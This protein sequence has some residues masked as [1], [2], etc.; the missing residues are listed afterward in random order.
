MDTKLH[1]DTESKVN[2][3]QNKE[4]QND[5]LSQNSPEHMNITEDPP[6]SPKPTCKEE[7]IT[8]ANEVIGSRNS[9][10]NIDTK[11]CGDAE[12]KVTQGQNKENRDESMSQNNSDESMTSLP[13]DVTSGES[14]KT[15]EINEASETNQRKE[16]LTEKERIKSLEVCEKE[17]QQMQDISTEMKK[18]EKD[19]QIQESSMYHL[20]WM[21]WKGEQTPIVTQNENG[22]CPLLAIANVLILSRKIVLPKMQQLISGNQLM[23]YIGDCIL[24][25]A[26]KHEG[27]EE[28]ILNYQQN[29][30]D[31]IDIMHKLQTG[32]DV[33]V[34]FSGVTDF[35]FTPECIVFDLLKIILYHG[36]LVDPQDGAT[37]KVVHNLSYNQLVEK[38]LIS[39][40][41]EGEVVVN[42]LVIEEFLNRTASQLT[43]HGLCEL[44]ST[45]QDEELCVF[46]RNNH[47]STLYKHKGELFLLVTD[48]GFLTEPAVAWETLI[49][50][51]GD[52]QFV[53][54]D[55]K[56]ITLQ[57]D[58]YPSQAK[59]TS[60]TQPPTLLPNHP[61][62]TPAIDQN[63]M[64]QEDRDYLIALSLQ[65]DDEPA[66][67]KEPPV[68][69]IDSDHA[70]AM[71][72]QEQEDRM[73]APARQP[74]PN[75]QQQLQPQQ[76]RQQR[77]HNTAAE[78]RNSQ[79]Q[80]T[81]GSEKKCSI[82]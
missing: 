27:N 46:F 74:S 37:W 53:N 6:M 64:S 60:S 11:Q 26:P 35:E 52:G 17:L 14:H 61:V 44:N 56:S 71:K 38:M 40:D 55:F 48:Q 81:Q 39:K 10:E 5:S 16:E 50:I 15:A 69:T 79:Q 75:Q 77:S 31:A 28:M 49:N 18:N 24:T 73:E 47:F 4:N 78:T 7:G 1:S 66:A 9:N 12:S 58:H 34:K 23:E 41:G 68:H 62:N 43:Y 70:L 25:E 57:N 22:P 13:E 36:W 67:I 42:G 32:I 30:Q 19:K 20:K 54:T 33:N 76:Q 45:I 63:N 65:Q 72:L 82:M 3:E 8:S 29:M 51:E 21:E 80:E 59:E 2:Q